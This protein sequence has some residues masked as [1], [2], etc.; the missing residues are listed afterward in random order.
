MIGD[1]L[2]NG[3]GSEKYIEKYKTC[4]VTFK[5]KE[6]KKRKIVHHVHAVVNEGR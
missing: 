6:K 1:S 5:K 3:R 2:E 4:R